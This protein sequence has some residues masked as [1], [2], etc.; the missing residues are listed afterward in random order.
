MRLN[1]VASAAVGGPLVTSFLVGHW[2]PL[3]LNQGVLGVRVSPVVAGP[4]RALGFHVRKDILTGLVRSF[5]RIPP[6]LNVERGTG[7]VTRI[8]H[9]VSQ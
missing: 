5:F 6:P 9:L 7:H 4:H 3:Q 2:L 1:V 8:Q